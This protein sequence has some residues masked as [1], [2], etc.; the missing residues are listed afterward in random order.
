LPSARTADDADEDRRRR[1]RRRYRSRGS[2]S[3]EQDMT[4]I[5]VSMPQ[6][7]FIR[8][9]EDEVAALAHIVDAAH[10]W[11]SLIATTDPAEFARAFTAVGLMFRKPEPVTTK[12]LTY[13]LSAANELLS[14]H[15]DAQPVSTNAFIGAVLAHAD[16]PWRRGDH[17]AG[18]TWEL[19]LDLYSGAPCSNRWRGLLD[20]T[21]N[22]LV[23]TPSKRERPEAMSQ[24]SFR[25][26]S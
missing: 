11:L 15:F 21:A 12:Y 2:T 10:P 7:G 24:V 25:T 26:G 17:L 19:G 6:T 16:I 13:H 14:E 4:R 9:S 23:A 8:P 3:A 20:G 22:L 5:I 18:Q 1:D